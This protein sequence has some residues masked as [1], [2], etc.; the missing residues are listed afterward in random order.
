MLLV[1]GALCLLSVETLS[2]HS[3]VL[4]KTTV[5]MQ[6]EAELASISVA[7]SMLDEILGANYDSA[8]IS[9]RVWVA[10]KFTPT[11]YLGP[12]ALNSITLPEQ[13]DTAT[14]Y[15]S[16]KKYDDVDDYNNYRRLYYSSTL[17]LFAVTDSVYYVDENDPT[18]KSS[19]QTFYKKI[20]ITVRHPNFCPVDIMGS[21]DMW[22][23]PYYVQM[24]DIAVYR[25]YF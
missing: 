11:A 10:S 19:G 16:L 25:T 22:S 24:V 5:M 14:S 3:L 21:Y 18:Q 15:Q 13:P 2:V 12:E 1:I 7:Q 8:T 4:S 6:S 9:K 20:V 17:G 23:S